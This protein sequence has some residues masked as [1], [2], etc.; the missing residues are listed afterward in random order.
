[1]IGSVNN[2][3]L[4][5][6]TGEKGPMHTLFIVT[7]FIVRELCMQCKFEM[8]QQVFICVFQSFDIVTNTNT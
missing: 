3:L 7:S 8:M 6:A 4:L 1:M 2:Y 5:L